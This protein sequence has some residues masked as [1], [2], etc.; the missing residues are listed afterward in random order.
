MGSNK[1]YGRDVVESH[2][3]ACLYAGVRICGC[4]AEVMPAQVSVRDVVTY[5]IAMTS[6][7]E[8]SKTRDP[9]RGVEECR[10]G[11]RATDAESNV[12]GSID[13]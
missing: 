13:V 3:R 5:V 7:N 8:A 11:S 4:N 10:Q 12:D 1:V 6:M 9:K 2:Y